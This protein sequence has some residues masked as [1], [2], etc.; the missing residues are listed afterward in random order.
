VI[1][2]PN[3]RFGILVADVSGKGM[4]AALYMA[5]SRTLLRT[6]A[7]QYQARPDH[8]FSVANR[9]ILMDTDAK[10]F[11]TAFYGILDPVTGTLTYCNAGHNPP[12]LLSSQNESPVQELRRTGIPLGVFRGET[13]EHGVVQFAP[14]DV[15]VLYTDGV[16]DAQDEHETFFDEERLCETAQANLGRPAQDV[17]DGLIAAVQEFVGDAPQF[18]DITVMVVVRG[19]PEEQGGK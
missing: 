10:M 9:R 15:L 13:W 14:G 8:V 2:L 6:Y 19:S 5:L 7:I 3:G 16:T 12:C 18:D 11:V 4:G 1:P 17:Q